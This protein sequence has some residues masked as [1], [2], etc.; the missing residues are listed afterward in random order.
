MRGLFRRTV[1]AHE[2]QCPECADAV[3]RACAGLGGPG[4]TAL[5]RGHLDVAARAHVHA[6]AQVASKS[7]TAFK[8]TAEKASTAPNEP[9]RARLGVGEHAEA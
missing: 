1:D 4:P 5:A 7:L 6:V 3:A 2:T 8:R 9:K